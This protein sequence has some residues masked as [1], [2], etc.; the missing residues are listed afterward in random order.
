M[1]TKTS[2]RMCIYGRRDVHVYVRVRA[3]VC[4]C[5][6]VCVCTSSRLAECVLDRSAAE[7][8]VGADVEGLGAVAAFFFLSVRGLSR[9]SST[10]ASA[11]R[12]HK[13]RG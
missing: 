7:E 4:V 11:R 1:F 13:H 9:D 10:V 6:C 5:V 3:C 12:H 8:R 2:I